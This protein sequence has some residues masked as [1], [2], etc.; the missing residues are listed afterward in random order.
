MGVESV[1]GVGELGRDVGL[2]DECRGGVKEDER[3][4]GRGWMGESAFW[5]EKGWGYSV[6]VMEC[7]CG[8]V[9]MMDSEDVIC[10][11]GRGGGGTVE[12]CGEDAILEEWKG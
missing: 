11:K 1:M 7:V 4:E 9:M 12:G 8:A 5:K 3:G 10:E 2:C 6:L